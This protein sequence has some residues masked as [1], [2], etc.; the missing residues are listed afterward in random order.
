MYPLL[1][2][3]TFPEKKIKWSEKKKKKPAKFLKLNANTYANILFHPVLWWELYHIFRDSNVIKK[4]K[5]IILKQVLYYC[6]LV[7]AGPWIVF[8]NNYSFK[9]YFSDVEIIKCIKDKKYEKILLRQYSSVS[10][11]CIE[12]ISFAV[13]VKSYS[14][15]LRQKDISYFTVR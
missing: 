14:N 11:L 8:S 12:K 5:F 13:L 3:D 1:L 4:K 15:K 6:Y 10:L 2:S 7:Y 9:R